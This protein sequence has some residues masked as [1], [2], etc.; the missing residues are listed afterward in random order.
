[1]EK[2]WRTP[3]LRQQPVLRIKEIPRTGSCQ[4]V[5]SHHWFKHSRSALLSTSLVFISRLLLSLHQ[6]IF[7]NS[8][9]KNN[10]DF[11]QKL[12][13]IQP[14][15]FRNGNEENLKYHNLRVTSIFNHWPKIYMRK[16]NFQR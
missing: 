16:G 15:Q 3:D 5:E 4:P 13:Y 8:S 14:E 9:E 12:H 11:R 6:W 10:Q 1:M 2:S 7:L